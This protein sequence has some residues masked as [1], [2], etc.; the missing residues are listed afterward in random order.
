MV[1]PFGRYMVFS[2]GRCGLW[3]IWLWPIWYRPYLV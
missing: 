3:P 1:I 2:C